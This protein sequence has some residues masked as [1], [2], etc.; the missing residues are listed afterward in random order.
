MQSD[1][2]GLP[3]AGTQTRQ[4]VLTFSQ[5]LLQHLQLLLSLGQG[6]RGCLAAAKGGGAGGAEAGWGRWPRRLGEPT[7]CGDK[8][9]MKA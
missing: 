8:G 9:R 1:T 6:D 2:G 7:Q 5:L 4:D 3:F